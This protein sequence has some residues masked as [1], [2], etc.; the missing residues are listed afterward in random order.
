VLGKGGV[1]RRRPLLPK[2]CVL[3]GSDLGRTA[4]TRSRGKPVGGG[5][6]RP[7]TLRPRVDAEAALD[8]ARGHAG[9]AGTQGSFAE[10]ERIGARHA[11]RVTNGQRLRNPL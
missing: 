1:G 11:A 8:H 3:G 6:L 7:P 9:I 5:P 4:R 2:S 10:I